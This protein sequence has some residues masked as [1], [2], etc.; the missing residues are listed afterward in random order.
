MSLSLCLC[1]G[2]EAIK[3]EHAQDLGLSS[4]FWLLYICS[5]FI[6][7][8]RPSPVVI[9]VPFWEWDYNSTGEVFF[10]CSV[11]SAQAYLGH[12]ELIYFSCLQ[13][14]QVAHSTG[15]PQTL[16]LEWQELQSF[17]A[18]WH[19]QDKSWLW[20]AHQFTQHTLS[21]ITFSGIP[22]W[23][24]KDIAGSQRSGSTVW[25]CGSLWPSLKLLPWWFEKAGEYVFPVRKCPNVCRR[26]PLVADKQIS[27]SS[28]TRCIVT[29]STLVSLFSGMGLCTQTVWM[30]PEFQFTTTVFMSMATKL[31]NLD[32][33]NPEVKIQT[34]GYILTPTSS[35]N[36][37]EDPEAF[38][39]APSHSPSRS[40][41]RKPM[42]DLP[43]TLVLFRNTGG[44]LLRIRKRYHHNL[45]P[46]RH[47]L[48]KICFMGRQ[49]W[50]NR[51]CSDQPRMR[52][53]VLWV[54][55][56]RRRTEFGWGK[57]CH[58]FTLSGVIAWVGKQV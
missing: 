12:P 44:F 49:T 36:G 5:H 40:A 30:Y 6:R 2:Q 4:G 58:M 32:E 18:N 38:G 25:N 55:F 37:P 53:L 43:E 7:S 11:I 45:T 52:Y 16:E 50:L 54:S 35:Q 34:E 42:P 9:L 47:W 46:G 39:S 51:S 13:A 28:W 8:H 31:S 57:R 41:T 10:I 19:M 1:R 29:A 48:W 22:G 17:S 15:S 20:W 23:A 14:S 26:N 27:A 33:L 24:W 3:G 56:V 21:K